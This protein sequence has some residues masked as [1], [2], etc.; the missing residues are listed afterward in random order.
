M[1][2]KFMREALKEAKKALE[3]EEVPVG[4]VIVK[5][6][7]IIARAHNTKETKKDATCHAEILAIQKACKKIG[8]WRLLDCEMYVTLEP[9]SM[10]AGALIN[11][12]IKKLYIGT[13]DNKT[14]AC[15]SV[16]NLLEDYKFNHKIEIEKYIL[17][18]ECEDELKKFFKYLRERNKSK[19]KS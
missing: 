11:S 9:C 15:G 5:D 13:D 8:A 7:K 2:E 16:L 10:C 12:R 18:N 6:G 14:G 1:E 19:K 17:K 3:I 4:A